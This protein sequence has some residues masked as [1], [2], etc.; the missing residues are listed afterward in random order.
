MSTPRGFEEEI[1]RLRDRI[2][3][4]LGNSA[5]MEV[6]ELMDVVDWMPALDVL[7]NKDDI[8]VRV[9]VPGVNP[10]EIDLSIS[11]DVIQIKGER[12]QETERDDENYHAI[13]R[14]FGSFDRRINLPAP[15][16]VESIKASYKNGVLII[17]LP[18][19]GEEE[20]GAVKV[21]LE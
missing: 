15:V 5:G 8:V 16:D 3:E 9:D 14:G 2:N 6:P 18:K 19:L 7:E 4:I 17:S 10:D 20:T 1:V 21:D 11:G 13:E 12:K